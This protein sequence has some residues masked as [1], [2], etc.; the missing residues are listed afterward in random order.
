[1]I[2]NLTSCFNVNNNDNINDSVKSK[3]PFIEGVTEK[4]E[5]IMYY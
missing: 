5:Y 2:S 3:Y 1:V 4:V